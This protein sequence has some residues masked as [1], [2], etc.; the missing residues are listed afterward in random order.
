MWYPATVTVAAAA[1][2]ITLA[3]AKTHC[4]V[5]GSAED[6]L[7]QGL[8]AAARDYVEAWTGCPIVS[9]TV[10]IICDDFADF[11]AVPV[12]VISISSVSYI[13]AN[14]TAL[15][16][17]ENVYEARSDGLTASIALKF[18]QVWPSIQAGSRITVTAI[19]GYSSVP[20]AL[21]HATMLLVGEWYRSREN[22]AFGSNQPTEL[23]HAVTA[24]L[25]NH[26]IFG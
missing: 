23:P 17:P 24:L 22:S 8:I 11:S 18:G 10:A 9:R 19:V 5:D 20:E 1:E 21:R 4:R 16:L 15:A 25:T 7:I 12:P 13:D 6:T 2:P 26:R 14:G 3:E